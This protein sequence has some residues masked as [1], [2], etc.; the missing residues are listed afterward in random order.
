MGTQFGSLKCWSCFAL[1][2]LYVQMFFEACKHISLADDFK[3]CN[4]G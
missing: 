2:C 4:K 1:V 3:L